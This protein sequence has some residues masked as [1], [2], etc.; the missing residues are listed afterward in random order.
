M[1]A[2]LQMLHL[3]DLLATL[4]WSEISKFN[5]HYCWTPGSFHQ[6]FVCHPF[7]G[8]NSRHKIIV[9]GWQEIN[10]VSLYN[11]E[12]H[13]HGGAKWS[14]DQLSVSIRD[15]AE[16]DGVE[17]V[18]EAPQRLQQKFRSVPRTAK[19]SGWYRLSGVARE[20]LA[21]RRKA[22]PLS[23]ARWLLS[24]SPGRQL[25]SRSCRPISVT[26]YPGLVTSS[27]DTE[28]AFSWKHWQWRSSLIMDEGLVI[29]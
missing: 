15:E 13:S 8:F 14:S 29:D 5:D 28:P 19:L 27:R 17:L 20:N 21:A 6:G 24:H 18:P 7:A 22:V 4:R 16:V 23:L 2:C 3:R 26:T 10:I 25:A 1:K 9:Q 12:V 11:S